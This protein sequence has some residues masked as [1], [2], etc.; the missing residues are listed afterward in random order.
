MINLIWALMA[1]IGIVYAMLNGTMDK[2][3]EAVFEGAND[4]ITLVIALTSVLVFWL[5][6]MKI[7]EEAGI[8][9]GLSK[10]FK[11]IVTRIFPDIP[12]DHPAMGY[13]LANFS[14]NLFGL[15]N[16][17]TPMGIKA[18][19]EM[20]KLNNSAAYASNSMITFLVINTSS[21]TLVPTQIIA[22]RMQY[23]SQ[24]PTEIV[25]TT[26][27]ASLVTTIS[28]LLIDAFLRKR[29]ELSSL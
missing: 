2:V 29:R 7:A 11:P 23:D 26:L 16:A 25:G 22:I 13:I 9:R 12:P 4:A 27:I 17:A 8:L 14:A 6:M 20:K 5:G 1:S 3:N 21:I 28:A 24:S 18:M 19:E 10:L 15:G